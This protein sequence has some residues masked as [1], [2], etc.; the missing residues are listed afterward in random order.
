MKRFII[1]KKTRE[2]MYILLIESLMGDISPIFSESVLHDM[3]LNGLRAMD[4]DNLVSNLKDQWC[5][6]FHGFESKP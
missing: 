5:E 3:V 1:W 6:S 2:Y 4:L